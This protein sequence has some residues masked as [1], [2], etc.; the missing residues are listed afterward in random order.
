MTPFTITL[1]K[2]PSANK[3]WRYIPGRV[4]KS[5]EYRHWLSEC[6]D[7]V[8]V[9]NTGRATLLGPVTVAIVYSPK[10]GRYMDCDAPIKPVLDL[11]E[12]AGVYAND[13]QVC[14]VLAHRTEPNRKETFVRVTVAPAEVPLRTPGSPSPQCTDT[15]PHSDR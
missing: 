4:L 14:T 8:W 10:D 6:M 12:A 2:P 9:A 7:M 11:L 3:I 5:K 13:R 15:S 1:P